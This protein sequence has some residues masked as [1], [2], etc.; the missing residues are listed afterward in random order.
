MSRNNRLGQVRR[1]QVLGYGPG[2]IIDFRA[3]QQGGGPISV[4]AGSLESWEETARTNGANDPQIVYEEGL[5]KVLGKQYF[6]LPPVD[7]SE[8]NE[9]LNRW[10]RGFRF[11]H[12]L[13]CPSCK[14][15]IPSSK[16]ARELG[17]PSRWCQPCSAAARRRVFVVPSR[18][19]TACEN[20]HI[21]EFPWRWWLR[22]RS[23][24]RAAC[25]GGATIVP[26][27][28]TWKASGVAGSKA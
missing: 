22:T 14:E 2:A 12:W 23:A 10:L 9:P 24:S 18:F 5:Q 19:V 20:G 4:I 25:D 28:S 6:R 21:D 7:D 8:E 11:P 15:L 3:G 13:Q 1:S 17:D 26:A 27:V 16:W